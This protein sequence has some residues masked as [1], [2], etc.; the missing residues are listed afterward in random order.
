[1]SDIAPFVAA[2]L[3]DRA[4]EECLEEIRLLRE[5]IEQLRGGIRDVVVQWAGPP[6]DRDEYIELGYEFD[7]NGWAIYTSRTADLSSEEE[8]GHIFPLNFGGGTLFVPVGFRFFLQSEI[9]F[10][11]FF[12]IPASE[13]SL[14][15]YV[16]CVRRNRHSRQVE[17]TLSLVAEF[18]D[19]DSGETV[20]SD[21]EVYMQDVSIEQWAELSGLST[22]Q[23]QSKFNID[24]LEEEW[25]QMDEADRRRSPF[26]WMD[27]G[28]LGHS[29]SRVLIQPD[30]L[31]RVL[32]PNFRLAIFSIDCSFALIKQKCH[33][34]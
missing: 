26:G 9:R 2:V 32:E 6:E 28:R 20:S 27:I 14:F 11:N 33:L 17:F 31:E 1:M 25:N 22:E 18:V 34:L 15:C 19:D 21:M 8:D 12:V 5:K 16:R 23:I 29:Y 13:L 10:G 24:E 30:I 7:R 4:L 3:R